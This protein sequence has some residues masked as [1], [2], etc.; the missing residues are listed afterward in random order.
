MYPCVRPSDTV[1]YRTAL[2]KHME[3]L[4]HSALH[5]TIAG[6]SAWWWKDVI[7]RKSLFEECFGERYCPRIFV[8]EDQFNFIELIFVLDSCEYC[9][10]CP[11][12][13]C[14]GVYQTRRILLL[15]H[16]KPTFEPNH[17]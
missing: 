11:H 10:R 12:T 14:C 13:R 3:G 16:V 1:A 8:Y 7:I 4:K 2:I 6:G 9:S 5:P 15:T 17:R